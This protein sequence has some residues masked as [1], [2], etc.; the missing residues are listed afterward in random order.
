M[1]VGYWGQQNFGM[2]QYQHRVMTSGHISEATQNWGFAGLAANTLGALT[3]GEE[4][5]TLGVLGNLFS[6]IA[7]IRA[8]HEVD[9]YEETSFRSTQQQSSWGGTQ[10]MPWG[11]QYPIM[12]NSGFQSGGFE[13]YQ[14][15]DVTY[16]HISEA[17]QNWGIAGL[18]ANTLGA[19]TGGEEGRNLNILGNLFSG[20]AN[21]RAMGEV[22][23]MHQESYSSGNWLNAWNSGW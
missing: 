10:V 7:Q 16:G 15:R 12:Q 3:G 13:N 1:T 21:I 23:T 14:H 22:N 11:P 2:Q 17:T 18:A 20:I 19:L 4:G 8:N 6:G 9:R 5:Q